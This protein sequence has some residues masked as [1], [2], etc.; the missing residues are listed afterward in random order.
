MS[1]LRHVRGLLDRI[2]PEFRAEEFLGRN[3]V[4]WN[5]TVRLKPDYDDAWLAACARRASVFFD[6]GA[7]V[8]FHS[9][10]AAVVGVRKL[11][12]IEPNPVALAVAAQNLIRNQLSD[13]ARF[14]PAFAS[15][16]TGNELDF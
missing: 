15:E 2:S 9:V 3:L 16:V 14:I 6:V 13:E 1:V 11:V 7:N 4:L 12:L 8:G 10:V 5:D